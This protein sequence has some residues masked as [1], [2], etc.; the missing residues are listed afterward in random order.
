MSGMFSQGSLQSFTHNIDLLLKKCWK[1]VHL[2]HF[3]CHLFYFVFQLNGFT[4]QCTTQLCLDSTMTCHWMEA[5]L[6]SMFKNTQVS[7][8]QLKSYENIL[9]SLC[10]PWPLMQR[11]SY[12]F[13]FANVRIP[14]TGVLVWW[15]STGWF[16]FFFFFSCLPP[17]S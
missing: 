10:I 17:Q 15:H 6:Q 11:H 2:F 1:R 16:G 12:V 9:F 5:L 7:G 14:N 3:H 8:V 4:L 13:V